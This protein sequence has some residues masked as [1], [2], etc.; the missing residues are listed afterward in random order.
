MKTAKSASQDFPKI[1][2]LTPYFWYLKPYWR[3]FSGAL[4][5]GAIY[6]ASSGFGLPFMTD[7]VFPLIFPAGENA[8]HLSNWEIFLLISWFP[9]VFIIRGM[10][11]FGNAYLI[12]YCGM[13]VLEQI[14][15]EVFAKIQRLPLSFFHRHSSGDLL[16]RVTGDTAQ[17]QN[18]IL[19]VSNDLI[20]Q[21]IT[22][23]GAIIA[24][25]VM[26]IK[27]EGMA[28]VLLCLLAIPLCV[29]PI[30]RIGALLMSKALRLQE[31]AGG[32]SSVLSEN[33]SGPADIRSLCLEEREILRFEEQSKK[34]FFARMK[35]VKY[36]HALN[37][38]IE[39][40]T[41]SGVSLAILQ[42]A[43][44]SMKLDAVVPLIVA[45]YMSYEPVKKLGA[46]HNVIKQ[47][48]A[49]LKRLQEILFSEET[50]SSPALP[51]PLVKPKGELTFENVSFRYPSAKDQGTSE[52]SA[53]IDSVNLVIKPGETIALVGPSGSG[54]TTFGALINRLH[55][56]TQ[57]RILLD[58]VDLRELDLGE[59]R[60]S[61]ASVPQK[62]FFFNDTIE[63]NVLLGRS[64]HT[65]NSVFNAL[66]LAN[67]WEFVSMLPHKEK[68]TVG[69]KGSRLSGGQLQ[70]L[71]LARAFY[72]N[73][74]VLLLDEATSAL[75]SENEERVH[76]AMSKLVQGKTTILI[77]HRFSSI[78]LATRIIVLERG[79]VIA[80]GN[81]EELY[82]RCQLYRKLFDGQSDG[83][84]FE[85]SSSN[86]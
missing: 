54:K 82:S 43:S 5:L 63:E 39:V 40:I 73:S 58:G 36:Y 78:R 76:E 69:E 51:V 81:H 67:A 47:G 70:R 64:V 66:E 79:K 72:R 71:A 38:M 15:M 4:L 31:Q 17:L 68:E 27:N 59:L 65:E 77:A 37:P 19:S 75:D 21:P 12:N 7:Q 26:A 6:G 29:F 48:L 41:V 3:P 52:H 49:S 14:R 2:S 50:V 30:R 46:I 9:L 55:D 24:L 34:I 74:P 1:G 53:A 20:R 80:D 84:A 32:L 83:Q 62:P 45:L 57:G 33:L 18:A 25:C 22:F 16:S 23:A 28:F 42:A 8:I 10:S 85:T 86:E 44:I 11:G 61:V 60:E 56:P 35:V 13:K